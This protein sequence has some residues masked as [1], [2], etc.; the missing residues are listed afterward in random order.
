MSDDTHINVRRGTKSVRRSIA[1]PDH[2]MYGVPS[3]SYMGMPFLPLGTVAQA[4]GVEGGV[5]IGLSLAGLTHIASM[6][7]RLKFPYCENF[8][9][10]WFVKRGIADA[11]KSLTR[12]YIR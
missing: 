12:V 2:F 8:I 9:A 11:F 7:I 5:F 6:L 3:I 10:Y 1:E 4:L